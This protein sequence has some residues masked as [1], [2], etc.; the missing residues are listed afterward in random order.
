MPR[1]SKRSQAARMRWQR[2]GE[3]HCATVSEQEE[4]VGPQSS[5][6]VMTSAASHVPSVNQGDHHDALSTPHISYA[7]IVKM[8]LHSNDPGVIATSSANQV[9]HSGDVPLPEVSY[10]DMVRTTL[11]GNDPGVAANS[12]ANQV[13]HS[14]DVPVPQVSYA[15]MV[16]RGCHSNDP[17]CYTVSFSGDVHPISESDIVE[18]ELSVAGPSNANY[19]SL[20]EQP[21]EQHVCASCSQASLKYGKF[22]NQ[23][24][25]CNSLTF[26]AFLYE[27]EN[28]TR[29]DLDLVLDKGNILYK[30]ARKRFPDHSHLTTDELPDKVRT[31]RHRLDVDMKILSKYGTFG[32]PLPGAVDDFLDLEAGLS[33]LLTE[34]QYAL[35]MMRSLCIAVFRTRSGRYGF[36]DPHSRTAK[37]LP[38][39]LGSVMA[40]TAVMLTFTHLSDMIDRLMKQH[41]M[42]DTHSS[43]T[44]ELKPVEFYSVDT[45]NQTCSVHPQLRLLLYQLLCWKMLFRRSQA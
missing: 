4:G 23:Q 15:D 41:K 11:Q 30:E 34:V 33:C 37:G 25:T 39:S 8:T 43:S 14:G 38:V 2:S 5:G 16:K 32:E 9:N 42:M 27:N 31:R 7:D 44:Y 12:N 20:T 35:L 19:V 3:M 18:A 29:A 17:S 6:E 10:A 1:K 21:S 36:F 28:M 26:L 40:G 13:N 45:T 24:C 22:R